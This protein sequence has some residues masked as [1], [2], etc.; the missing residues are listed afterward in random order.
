MY[1]K[2]ESEERKRMKKATRDLSNQGGHLT[3]QRNYSKHHV[4]S[5]HEEV[6]YNCDQCNYKATQK[7]QLKQHVE[8]IHETVF[9]NCDQCDYKAKRKAKYKATCKFKV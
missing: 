9:Q 4:Q 5:H 8:T 2:N 7:A 6:Q 1:E 3:P